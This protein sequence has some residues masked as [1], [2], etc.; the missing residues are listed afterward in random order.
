MVKTVKEA[1]VVDSC[2][3]D[4]DKAAALREKIEAEYYLTLTAVLKP[5]DLNRLSP[6]ITGIIKLNAVDRMKVILAVRKLDALLQ[7]KTAS[8][9]TYRD[10]LFAK[11]PK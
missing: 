6:L 7:T 11:I 3:A 1:H 9:Q 4:S 5:R 10:V 2:V 8:K